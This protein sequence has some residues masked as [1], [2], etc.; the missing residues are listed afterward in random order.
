[1]QMNSQMKTIQLD[2]QTDRQS[3]QI[4]GR[5]NWQPD[6]DGQT[7]KLDRRTDIHIKYVN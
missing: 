5:R 7:D 4:D 1:M 3:D 2:G 6:T